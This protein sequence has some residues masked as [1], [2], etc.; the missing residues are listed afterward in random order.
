MSPPL[1]RSETINE[2][3]RRYFNGLGRYDSL[4]SICELR[5]RFWRADG[6]PLNHDP[7]V[8]LNTQELEPLYEENSCMYLFSKSSFFAAYSNRIGQ[9]PTFFPMQKCESLDIDT[10]DDFHLA[11]IAWKTI[12]NRLRKDVLNA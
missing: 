4:F 1:I 7:A 2:A 11:E 5:S 9:Y 12:E 10:V 8:L 3:V 6:S